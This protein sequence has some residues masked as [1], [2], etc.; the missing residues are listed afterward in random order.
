MTDAPLACLIS[1]HCATDPDSPSK[2]GLRFTAADCTS[3]TGLT[4]QKSTGRPPAALRSTPGQLCPRSSRHLC[5]HG[6]SPQGLYQRPPTSSGHLSN[7][8]HDHCFP[9]PP[10]H[11]VSPLPPSHVAQHRHPLAQGLRRNSRSWLA[12]HSLKGKACCT[13]RPA[14][15][16]AT[17][18][19][20]ATG[21][22]LCA[23]SLSPALLPCYNRL[24]VFP[25]C[26]PPHPTA[27]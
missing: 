4:F 13:R 19:S 3:L 23:P 12:T 14:C 21:P 20:P 18:S 25:R 22:T 27:A 11:A 9:C 15:P 6:H 16:S 5:Q 8:H 26:H 2:S 24:T 7:F 10:P 17:S 1:T